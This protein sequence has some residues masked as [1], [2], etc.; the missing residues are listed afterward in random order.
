LTTTKGFPKIELMPKETRTYRDRAKYNIQ[1]VTKRRKRLKEMAVKS[2]G[3]KCQICG[4]S[5]LISAL[6]FHH[7]DEN[8]KNFGLSTRGLTRSWEKIRTE[9]KKC[10]LVCANCHREIHGGLIAA[11]GRN[12]GMKTGRIVGKP[13]S[14]IN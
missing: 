13:K 6:E 1:A 12:A 8:N 14:K 9:T 11:S 4:Y 5:R 2:K 10:I 7:L 3:G